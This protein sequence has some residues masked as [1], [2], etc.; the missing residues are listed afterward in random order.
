MILLKFKVILYRGINLR[1]LAEI[2]FHWQGTREQGFH[3]F[4]LVYT[5]KIFFIDC[6][7]YCIK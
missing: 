1:I 7:Y 3:A 5:L 4:N 6:R 2:N